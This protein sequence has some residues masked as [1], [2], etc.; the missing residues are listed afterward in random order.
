MKAFLAR[1]WFLLALAVMMAAGF[2][3]AGSPQMA[4]L[5]RLAES[6]GVRY[7][8]VAVVL[9]LMALPLE[10]R[11]MWRTLGSPGPPLLGVAMNSIALPLVAW[12][13][14]ATVGHLLL[15][16][17]MALGLLTAAA[18]PCTL[19][20]AAV[21]TRRAGGND[22]I[23]IM[24][25]VITN[26]SCFLVTPF[27]LWQMTGESAQIDAPQMIV[28]LALFVVLPMVLAQ[29]TRMARVIGRWATE[30]A[31]AFGATAQVGVLIMI[32]F[33]SVQAAQRFA[34]HGG[35]P[36]VVELLVVVVAVVV[37]HVTVLAA[38]MFCARRLKMERGS[39]IAVG[40]AGSQ[41]TL[42]VGLQMCME[43]GFNIVPMVAFHVSQ[44]LVDTVIAD[45][46][47]S[48]RRS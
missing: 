7:G 18:T 19:A 11:A 3:G 28:K 32:F 40:F 35:R 21:W 4:P 23:S 12:S 16:R 6:V 15:S 26:A 33:G 38:G 17:D 24:V 27:W 22:A 20:S 29:V 36:I 2:C 1:R 31:V 41:K 44:L 10:A 8:V 47:R 39:Q 45:R 34:R 42:M 5:V 46:L 37:I 25:T 43:L 30:H 9:F 14:V 48:S 13:L